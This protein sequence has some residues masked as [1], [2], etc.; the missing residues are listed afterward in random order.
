MDHV[1]ND[2]TV[3]LTDLHKKHILGLYENVLAFALDVDKINRTTLD[4]YILVGSFIP[5]LSDL[6]QSMAVGEVEESD[7]VEEV[8][9]RT[10]RL[11]DLFIYVFDATPE[12]ASMATLKKVTFLQGA[13]DGELATLANR[14]LGAAFS[15]FNSNLFGDSQQSCIWDTQ[16]VLIKCSE[17]DT[18]RLAYRSWLW[19][20]S[21][22]ELSGSLHFQEIVGNDQYWHFLID[23]LMGGSH[24]IRRFCVPIILRSL[25]QVARNIDCDL[26]Q[27]DL[28]RR[29]RQLSEWRRFCAILEIVSVDASVNQAQDALPDMLHMLSARSEIPPYWVTSLLRLAMRSSMEQIRALVAGTLLRLAS[30]DLARFRHDLKLLTDVVLRHAM[31]APLFQVMRVPEDKCQ[32][33]WS[34]HALLV[35]EFVARMIEGLDD[36]AAREAVTA[37]L[38]L[39]DDLQTSFDHARLYVLRGVREGLFRSRSGGARLPLVYASINGVPPNADPWLYRTRWEEGTK[40][41]ILTSNHMALLRKVAEIPFESPMRASAAVLYLV[42]IL[43]AVS[44]EFVNTEW[45]QSLSGVARGYGKVMSR[46]WDDLAGFM[47]VH[48]IFEEALRGDILDAPTY[49]ALFAR[50]LDCRSVVKPSDWRDLGLDDYCAIIEY[51]QY[52]PVVSRFVQTDDFRAKLCQQLQEQFAARRV[53]LA[54]ASVLTT[55]SPALG[56]TPIEWANLPGHER[57]ICDISAG[58]LSD[59]AAILSFMA[60]FAG[61]QFASTTDDDI[62]AVLE[63]VNTAI[64]PSVPVK[65]RKHREDA[66]TAAFLY[67]RSRLRLLPK[68]DHCSAVLEAVSDLSDASGARKAIVAVLGAAIDRATPEDGNA[69]ASALGSLWFS[70]VE[71]RL[72]AVERDLHVAF[73]ETAFCPKAVTLG[74]PNLPEIAQS[75]IS[76]SFARRNMLLPLARTLT[77]ASS[78]L[79]EWIGRTLVD[80]HAHIQITDA[81]FRLEEVLA[82]DIDR[83]LGLEVGNWFYNAFCTAPE[84]AARAV[85]IRHLAERTE[86]APSVFDYV[87]T[88]PQYHIFKPRKRVDD[89]E[90]QTRVQCYQVLLVTE[91]HLSDAAALEVLENRFVP[92]IDTEPSQCVRLYVEWLVARIAG[93]DP[94]KHARPLVFEAL[95]KTELP[96]R[97]SNSFQRIGLLLSRHLVR[98]NA[99]N[100]PAFYRD[101]VQAML[102][103]ATS[104]RAAIRH[105]STAMLYGVQ[106]DIESNTAIASILADYAAVISGIARVASAA[107]SFEF[108]WA[109]E[110]FVW[111]LDDTGLDKVTGGVLRRVTERELYIIPPSVLADYAGVPIP[112]LQSSTS[113]P[114]PTIECVNLEEQ[115]ASSSALVTQRALQTK[116]G[117]YESFANGDDDHLVKRGELIVI[118][119]LVDKAPNLGG[120]CRLCDALGARLLCLDDMSVTKTTDFKGVAVTADQWMPMK[121]VPV[122]DIAQYMR[123]QKRAGYTLVGLEQTDNSV[124]LGPD[125]KFPRKTVLLIGKE[126]EGIPGELLAELDLCVEIKQVGVVRSMNI[127]TATAIAVHA[128]SAQHC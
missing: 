12:A 2:K 78:P 22:M 103:L 20:V 30:V 64:A 108:F 82:A 86:L 96:P 26:M 14:A 115:A 109:G 56:K 35:S 28:D 66:I 83:E 101:Y 48:G 42:E 120:I 59:K 76:Q 3:K 41:Q 81:S 87:L 70:L 7:D 37:V 15:R 61:S 55:L 23:G 84:S 40:R 33:Y 62:S 49:A 100:G 72:I 124:E 53:S 27:F 113:T 117:A 6:K 45:I 126:S 88:A 1:L 24:D 60:V 98:K 69:L 116:S 54:A 118:A 107:E 90:E 51:A 105:F 68:T 39:L 80:I 125:L 121:E 110:R 127:Q 25:E 111:D 93:R 85:A 8:G 77:S 44:P 50:G 36:E 57:T 34:P 9:R 18:R 5:E 97:I 19:M 94:V 29:D 38:E 11:L 95:K 52:N 58:E 74:V 67:L 73:I 119:S 99:P 92:A 17:P 21:H 128:Y 102:P 10:K 46:V 104:N 112:Q 31:Q 71:D 65:D 91:K 75:V 16:R 114:E 123:E 79:P 47:L 4:K 43:M 13:A 63:V 106:E 122:T 32:R 89:I